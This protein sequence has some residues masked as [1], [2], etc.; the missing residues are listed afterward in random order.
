MTNEAKLHVGAR[1]K[2]ISPDIEPLCM[3]EPNP[4]GSTNYTGSS[5]TVSKYSVVDRVQTSS[6]TIDK[7]SNASVKEECKL[8]VSNRKEDKK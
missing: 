6:T 7:S 5:T 2:S 1:I 8:D 3:Q 4:L